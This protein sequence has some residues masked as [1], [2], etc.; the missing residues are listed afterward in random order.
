MKRGMGKMTVPD[1]MIP[2]SD[3]IGR[4]LE[5]SGQVRLAA[6]QRQRH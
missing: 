3:G 2:V 1:L 6:G 5:E 4:T